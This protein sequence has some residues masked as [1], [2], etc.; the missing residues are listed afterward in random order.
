M[1]RKSSL[2][3]VAAI[4]TIALLGALLYSS[5]PLPP[6]LQPNI[7]VEEIPGSTFHSPDGTWWGYNQSKIVR[8]QEHVFSYYID[9]QDTDTKTASRFTLLKKRGNDAW[10]EGASFPTSR[11]GNILIDSIGTLHAFVFEPTNAAK[12][13]SWGKLVHYALPHA[14]SGDITTF[15]KEIVINN[16][17]Q[18]ETVNIRVGAAINEDGTM[19][20]GFGLPFG[21]PPY[22]GQSEHL[23]TKKLPDTAWQHLIAGQNL[24]HDFYYPFVAAGKNE[25]H[26]L[27]VQ[28]D[29]A[30][31]GNPATYDN[32][33]QKINLFSFMNNTWKN[34]SI[35]D[36]SHHPLHQKRPR[37]LE[38]EDLLLDK[39][40]TLHILYKEFLDPQYTY[41]TT[42][43]VH[44]HINQDGKQEKNVISGQEDLNWIR[45]FALKGELYY[46][47]SSFDS[48]Y[49]KKVN[50]E[51][52][53]KINIP[54]NAKGMYP[55]IA[56]GDD[57]KYLDILLLAADSKTYENGTNKNYY[58]RIPLTYF[59]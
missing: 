17:G 38:Q 6:I 35:V 46:F 12:N 37:L 36:L 57:G 22:S 25:F 24:G 10:Q 27:P 18:Q 59:H 19:A 7:L 51:L 30:D 3:T 53:S 16:T 56:K 26:L 9:N 21:V 1:S 23:Y 44:I 20:I 32:I 13:D 49:W 5:S 52:W 43:H 28:D 31:D 14:S 47:G 2:I 54:S 58:V 42:A 41:K 45:L 4:L 40:Q 55:Y 39:E 8:F 29:F 11:P 34:I 48:Y 33:Y 15:T 50:E